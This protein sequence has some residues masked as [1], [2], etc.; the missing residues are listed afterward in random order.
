MR[1]L[2][3]QGGAPAQVSQSEALVPRE[4]RA[5]PQQS[6]APA[7]QG[8]VRG[9]EVPAAPL[10][11]MVGT[12]QVPSAFVRNAPPPSYPASG[13]VG[14]ALA[15]AAAPTAAAVPPDLLTGGVGST[16]ERGMSGARVAFSKS[17]CRRPAL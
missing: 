8:V 10:L 2:R 16:P 12:G 1:E 17:H 14:A 3:G 11:P 6:A 5:P 13:D 15:A 7:D 4:P 9:A